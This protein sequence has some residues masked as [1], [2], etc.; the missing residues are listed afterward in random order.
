M[1]EL[2]SVRIHFSGK[3][4]SVRTGKCQNWKGPEPDSVRIEKC[5]NWIVSE[6]E[7]VRNCSD[8][9]LSETALIG[10]CQKLLRLECIRNWPV[11]KVSE[12]T[13]I[14]KCQKQLRFESVRIGN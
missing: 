13:Q 11:W 9:K 12:N 1:S 6:W 8:W 14:G 2:E 3:L 10:I 7:S 5:Q 4:E